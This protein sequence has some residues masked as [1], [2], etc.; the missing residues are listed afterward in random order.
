MP[1][2]M[3]YLRKIRKHLKIENVFNLKNIIN[4]KYNIKVMYRKP[5][6]WFV[7]SK[8]ICSYILH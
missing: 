8:I 6:W 7:K 1:L 4:F 2:E 3:Y 5:K